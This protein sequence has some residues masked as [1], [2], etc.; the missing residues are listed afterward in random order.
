MYGNKEKNFLYDIKQSHGI[1]YHHNIATANKM[2]IKRSFGIVCQARKKHGRFNG[3]ES[4]Q[5]DFHAGHPQNQNVTS[6]SSNYISDYKQ[7]YKDGWN[8]AQYSANV[9]ESSIR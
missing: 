2:P 8:D 6:A 5:S 1:D 7:G 9:L 3:Y 4:A